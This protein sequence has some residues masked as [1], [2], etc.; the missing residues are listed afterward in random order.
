MFMSYRKTSVEIDDSL[1]ERAKEI[2]ATRTVKETIDHAFREVLCQEAR[3]REVLELTSMNSLD[4]DDEEIMA[5]AW[6]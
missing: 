4:L 1:F 3:R 6:R 2:L 5:G